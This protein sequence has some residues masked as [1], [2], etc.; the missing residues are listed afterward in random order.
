MK[1]IDFENLEDEIYQEI[2]AE[3]EVCGKFDEE[4]CS[5]LTKEEIRLANNSRKL[6]E[7]LQVVASGLYD[8]R[9]HT[10]EKGQEASREQSLINHI[11]SVVAKAEGTK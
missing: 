11:I 10:R 2:K 6:L 3:M 9:D 4:T 1:I 7:A 5:R 8:L